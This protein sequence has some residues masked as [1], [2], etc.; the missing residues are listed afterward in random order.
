MKSF[1]QYIAE[2][3]LDTLESEFYYDRGVKVYP[4]VFVNPTAKELREL[5]DRKSIRAVI[6]DENTVYCFEASRLLHYAIVKYFK[7]KDPVTIMIF[8]EGG[9][10]VVIGVTDTM[11]G[12][13]WDH[14]P[15]IEE[16]IRSNKYLSK[17]FNITRI[18]YHDEEDNG[19][20]SK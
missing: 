1:K 15:H 13:A 4:E 7:L 19:K 8:M 12:S 14:N 20:W 11:D 17:T 5:T 18:A 10:N 9:K 6:V 16:Y 2:D 3:Y